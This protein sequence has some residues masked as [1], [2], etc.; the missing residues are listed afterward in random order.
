ML[1]EFLSIFQAR[2]CKVCGAPVPTVV[3]SLLRA[4]HPYLHDEPEAPDQ[5]SAYENTPEPASICKQGP[6]TGW[7]LLS[8]RQQLRDLRVRRQ[9]IC[10]VI[11][12]KRTIN[13]V[14]CRLDSGPIKLFL[15]LFHTPFPKHPLSLSPPL[16]V[17]ANLG[18]NE[19]WQHKFK[20]V[21]G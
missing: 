16:M 5:R 11:R 1:F 14:L 21:S 2:S 6:S 7:E 18:P 3:R 10:N 19:V 20:A 13:N 17:L 15:T 9:L 4:H 12:N 8:S